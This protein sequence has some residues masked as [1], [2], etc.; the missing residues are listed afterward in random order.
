MVKI[1]T[2]EKW[3][4]NIWKKI[5]APSISNAPSMLRNTVLTPIAPL[6]GLKCTPIAE[7]APLM[8]PYVAIWDYINRHQHTAYTKWK[9]WI[10]KIRYGHYFGCRWDSSMWLH[11]LYVQCLILYVEEGVERRWAYNYPLLL[12]GYWLSINR[13]DFGQCTVVRTDRL[14]RPILT[15]CHLHSN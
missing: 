13:I 12:K 8:H 7:S 10:V 4:Q 15:V 1:F 9:R 14:F 11:Y 2:I 6:T 3:F 5:D